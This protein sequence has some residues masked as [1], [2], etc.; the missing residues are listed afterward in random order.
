MFY[1]VTDNT[2]ES[3]NMNLGKTLKLQNLIQKLKLFQYILMS[4]VHT[5]KINK[6]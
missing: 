6:T 2:I 4:V 5:K 1:T 3:L